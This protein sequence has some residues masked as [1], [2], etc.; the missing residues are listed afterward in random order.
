MHPQLPRGG[1]RH[2]DPP[3]QGWSY[4]AGLMVKRFPIQ[5]ALLVLAIVLALPVW[6]ILEQQAQIREAQRDAGKRDVQIVALLRTIQTQRKVSS[7]LLC[8]DNEIILNVLGSIPA[9]ERRPVITA[10]IKS[11]RQVRC[12]DLIN[13]IQPPPS[14]KP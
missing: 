2:D 3:G 11:A 14:V 5:T 8:A 12:N 7:K 10:A 6:M 1:E 4:R 9:T 13:Q